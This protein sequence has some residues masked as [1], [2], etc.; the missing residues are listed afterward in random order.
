M[1]GGLVDAGELGG[2]RV[3]DKPEMIFPGRLLLTAA[4]KCQRPNDIGYRIL[5]SAY[6][7]LLFERP[8]QSDSGSKRFWVEQDPELVLG[9]NFSE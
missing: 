3:M 4:D 1:D 8:H 2:D 9:E 5:M 7:Y 6:D